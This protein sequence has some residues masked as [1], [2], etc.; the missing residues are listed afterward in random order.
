[1]EEIPV[2]HVFLSLVL[3]FT[4]ANHHSTV[5]FYLSLQ[6]P[7]VTNYPDWAAYNRTFNIYVWGLILRPHSRL[8]TVFEFTCLG[9]A[10][11]EIS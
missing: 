9:T 2:K 8:F 10:S 11:V 7:A 3:Q 5:D 6:P 4:S 1:M